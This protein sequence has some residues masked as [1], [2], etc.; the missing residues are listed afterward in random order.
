MRILIISQ[1]FWPE[2]FRVNDL[3]AGLVERGHQV[4]I[5]T[6][7]PNYPDGAVFVAFQ[8]DPSQFARFEGCEVLRVPMVARGKRKITLALNYLSFAVSAS[9]IGP[10]LLRGRSFEAIFVFEPSPI[11]VCLPGI[12]LRRL[13]RAPLALWVLD[14]WPDSLT[15]AGIL[16]PGRALNAVGRLVAFIY[17]RCDLILAQSRGFIPAI[18]RHCPDPGK[19]AYFPSWADK[20]PQPVER[21]P[22]PEV[23]EAP[24]MFTIVSTGNIGAAQD[25][26]TV[27][28][29]AKRLAHRDDIRWVIVGDGRMG[30]WLRGEVARAGLQDRVLLPGRFPITRMASF[31]AHADALLLSLKAEPIFALTIPGRFQ[32]YLME[33]KPLLAMIDGEVAEIVKRRGG[34]LACA[35]GDGEGLARAAMQMADMPPEDRAEMGRNNA[36][37]SAHEFA[38]DRLIDNLVARLESLGHS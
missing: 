27:L 33:G 2:V 8:R 11:T 15:A 28:D 3:V 1:Y 37:L 29:A 14:L 9:L 32:S 4:T 16:Q 30:N 21:A 18:E 38:R 26:P 24:E 7:K 36:D 19:I 35:A 5:L 12:V 10:V 17:G 23:P 34:G 22:A 25:M 13:K 6:G 31:Y 20:L